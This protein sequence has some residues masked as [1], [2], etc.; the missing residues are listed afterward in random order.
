MSQGLSCNCSRDVGGAASSEGLT[1]AGGSAFKTA[2]HM[3]VGCRPQFLTTAPL[4][5]AAW[6]SS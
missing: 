5:W 1:G 3:A 2:H 4:H 6:G